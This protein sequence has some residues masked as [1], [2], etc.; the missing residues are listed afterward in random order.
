MNMSVDIAKYLIEKKGMSIDDIAQS[1][2]SSK[3]H[4]QKIIDGIE[5]FHINNIDAYLKKNNITMLDFITQAVPLEH[6]PLKTRKK[7]ILCQKLSK[8]IKK[9]KN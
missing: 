5:T 9:R 8:R 3:E 6:I 2:D 7:I 4:I 1:M